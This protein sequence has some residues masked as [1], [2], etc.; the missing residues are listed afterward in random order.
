MDITLKEALIGFDRRI[1][2]LDG[3]EVRRA[4]AVP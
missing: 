1:R 4:D 2:H 3:R